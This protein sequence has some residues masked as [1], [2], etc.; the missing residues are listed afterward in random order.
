MARNLWAVLGVGAVLMAAGL[1]QVQAQNSGSQSKV[2][3]PSKNGRPMTFRKLRKVLQLTDDQAEQIRQQRAEFRKQ[4]A[5]LEGKIK[6]LMADY[7]TEMEKTDPDKEK[8]KE[9]AKN[10]SDLRGEKVQ[11]KINSR[12]EVRKLLTPEQLDKLKTIQ[13]EDWPD[14]DRKPDSK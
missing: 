1:S 3:V 8:V 6:V 10:I 9:I 5:V 4:M 13:A 12:L 7:E 14:Q 2:T 11:E